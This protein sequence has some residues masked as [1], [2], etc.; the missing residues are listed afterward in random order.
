MPC[1]CHVLLKDEV[2]HVDVHFLRQDNRQMPTWF[3]D[4]YCFP[5]HFRSTR[6]F[7]LASCCLS[8]LVIKPSMVLRQ[9]V[10]TNPQWKRTSS[11]LLCLFR[12]RFVWSFSHPQSHRHA[13]TR[14]ELRITQSNN[15][16]NSIM[17]GFSRAVGSRKWTVGIVKWAE[18]VG[19]FVFAPI[20]SGNPAAVGYK[21]AGEQWG[22]KS[23]NSRVRSEGGWI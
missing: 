14:T 3:F 18:S 23:G 16:L 5:L 21:S 11:Y 8:T 4:N 6:I 22:V 10:R 2:C 17:D 9:K 7:E 20:C 12:E 1:Q 15:W 19:N 13:H